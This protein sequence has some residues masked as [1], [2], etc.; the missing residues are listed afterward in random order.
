MGCDAMYNYSISQI[1]TL[2]ASAS[3]TL[4]GTSET[5]G[6]I[7][8][9]IAISSDTAPIRVE[10]FEGATVSGGSIFIPIAIDR[11]NTLESDINCVSNPT[12]SVAGD[13]IYQTLIIG[14]KHS[15][16]LSR[17]RENFYLKP[18]TTYIYKI[19]NSS[20]QSANIAIDLVWEEYK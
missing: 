17:S 2:A 8:N 4:A 14:D 6:I 18:N 9:P 11:M 16:G 3:I 5:S 19:T 20:A 13:L 10:L 12:I 1:I 7:F 15:G